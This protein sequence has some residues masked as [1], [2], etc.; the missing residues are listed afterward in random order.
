MA[1]RIA[2]AASDFQQERVGRAP[3]SVTVVLSADT[4]VITMRGAL[5]R[6]E[7]AVAKSP[8]GAARVQEFHRR[9]F[10]SSAE[11]MRQEIETITGVE[12]GETTA[13]CGPAAVVQAFTTGTMVQVFLLS[14]GVA[15][16]TWTM[17][18]P[19]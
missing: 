7:Q 2:Q 15:A 11:S 14:R 13:D 16:D 19:P 8:E 6:A 9:L 3:K 12:V 18:E 17:T 1:Q 4:L 10:A 5:S